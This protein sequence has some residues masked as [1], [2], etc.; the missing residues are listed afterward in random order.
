MNSSKNSV[1]TSAINFANAN[2][3]QSAQTLAQCPTDIGAEVAFAGRSNAGKSSAINRL[4]KQNKLARTSK[5]PGRTQLINFFALNDDAR[6]VDLPGYGYAKVPLA[7]KKKWEEHLTEYLNERESLRA[8][9]LLMDIRHP[10]QEFDKNFLNWASVSELPV[11]VLLTKCDKLKRGAAKS[12][13]LGVQ[14]EISKQ[15][16]DARF[17]VQLFSALKGDGLD[18]LGSRISG[19]L[20]NE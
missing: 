13:L 5:T 12:Q 17:S 6:L 7:V 20:T 10:L 4:T 3:L 16:L 15:K 18:E 19:W 14:R 9:V 11:H 2:F 8:C 1:Y